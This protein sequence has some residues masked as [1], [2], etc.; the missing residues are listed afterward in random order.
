MRSGLFLILFSVISLNLFGQDLAGFVN[1][2]I[3]TT[4]YGTTNPGAVLPNGMMSIA[5]FNVMGSEENRNPVL[6]C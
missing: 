3:G 4:N 5:P 1:P 6:F 2:F